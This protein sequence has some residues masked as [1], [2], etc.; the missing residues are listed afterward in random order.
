MKSYRERNKS[1]KSV[2]SSSDGS[3]GGGKTLGT[4]AAAGAGLG[5]D[6]NEKVAN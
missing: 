6:S 3:S 2:G 4:V 5:V 1:G